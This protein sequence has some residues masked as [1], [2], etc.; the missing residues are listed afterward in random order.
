MA[1]RS[2]SRQAAFDSKEYFATLDVE[3]AKYGRAL[4]GKIEWFQDFVRETGQ[5]SLWRRCYDYYYAGIRSS[6]HK[7]HD[8]GE[9]GEMSIVNIN[10]LRNLLLHL[11]NLITGQRVAWEAR[12]TNTDAKSMKQAKLANGLLDYYLREKTVGRD[13]KN[14]VELGLGFGEG[15][16]V[17][18]WD[19]QKGEIT[20]IEETEIE[21]EETGEKEKQEIP[22][23][24]GDVFYKVFSPIK[25]VRDVLKDSWA[26]CPW[27]I[28]I[29]SEN[30]FDMAARYPHLKSKILDVP[31]KNTTENELRLRTYS[32][33]ESDDVLVYTLYHDKTPSV[34][35]GRMTIFLDKDVILFDGPLPY[36][37]LNIHR[38]TP[39]DIPESTFGYSPIFDLLAIQEALN[40]LYSTVLSNQSAFGVQ[41]IAMPK[42][43]NIDITQ[44]TGLNILE[45]DPQVG[46]PE[47]INLVSTPAEIFEFIN[48]LEQVMEILSGVN[49]TA[50]GY[51]PANIQ[52]GAAMALVQQMTVQFANG[53][54]EDYV[55]L[56][57]DVG[58]DT[59]SILKQFA[60]TPRVAMVAGVNNKFHL[61]EFSGSSLE[62]VNRVHVDAGNPMA[63][64]VAGRYNTADILVQGGF[65]EN[66]DQ[67]VQILE[68]GQFEPVIQH[69]VN[70][71]LLIQDEN[72][73]MSNGE[74]VQA[75]ATDSHFQHI[76][77]HRGVLASVEARKDS[78]I[79]NAVLDH[80]NE[81]LMLLRETD[82]DLLNAIGQQS[83]AAP[84]QQQPGGQ[85]PGGGAGQTP[86]GIPE[87]ATADQVQ[88]PENPLTGEQVS[89]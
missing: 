86:G 53:L 37:R 57:E 71:T 25:L 89:F 10:H 77:E 68:T 26:E 28:T 62:Y 43:A 4:M 60:T 76:L 20:N 34:P 87:P 13:I 79:V 59:I 16:V 29:E 18:G 40:G 33:R 6:G 8:A 52:S 50:R 49:S 84:P 81:H 21:D 64:T 73:A 11:L 42:G 30:R 47:P 67:V 78:D 74:Q 83:L 1:R 9:S 23:K 35:N 55:N 45:Y 80:I 3:D 14:A 61:K 88:M 31:T 41:N 46:K 63:N 72:E 44:V 69:K 2:I 27:G 56:L 75:V 65:V 48:K 38:V 24:A 36:E 7:V 12:A 70:E 82:P 15:F 66:G 51:P 17:T 32:K 5:L 85:M 22:Q 19:A 39:G 58:T 54:Q